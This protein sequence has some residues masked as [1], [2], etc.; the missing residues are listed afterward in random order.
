MMEVRGRCGSV[1]LFQRP[2]QAGG[3]VVWLN[4]R[5]EPLRRRRLSPDEA[6]IVRRELMRSLNAT[7]TR[8]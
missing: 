1:E 7:E 3:P 2:D 6:E 5:G 8:P 4:L